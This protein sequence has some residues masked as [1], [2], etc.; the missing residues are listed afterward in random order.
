MKMSLYSVFDVKLGAYG[1]PFVSP[2]DDV[3]CRSFGLIVNEEG[4][5]VNSNPQD[6]TLFHVGDFDDTDGSITVVTPKSLGNGLEFIKAVTPIQ[7]P[8]FTGEN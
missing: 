1:R 5:Q 3:A 6:F 4:S 2:N 7:M 8:E